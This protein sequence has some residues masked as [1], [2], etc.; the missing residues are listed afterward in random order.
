MTYRQVLNIGDGDMPVTINYG[1]DDDCGVLFVESIKAGSFELLPYLDFAQI[2][3]IEHQLGK[4]HD[5][6]VREMDWLHG[7]DAAA[8]RDAFREAYKDYPL[9]I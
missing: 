7:E 1:I 3:S 9:G 2:K 5:N 6:I 4:R 8:D